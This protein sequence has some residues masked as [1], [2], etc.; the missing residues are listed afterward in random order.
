MDKGSNTTWCQVKSDKFTLPRMFGMFI[1]WGIR[2]TPS[3]QILSTSKACRVVLTPRQGFAEET[4]LSHLKRIYETKW[5][6][7]KYG[8]WSGYFVW[9]F[10]YSE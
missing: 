10:M 9:P 4:G 3:I 7:L 1:I 5:F 6:A 2:F 8:L